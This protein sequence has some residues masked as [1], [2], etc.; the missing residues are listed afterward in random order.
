MSDAKGPWPEWIDKLDPSGNSIFRCKDGRE[1]KHPGHPQNMRHGDPMPDPTFPTWPEDW[2]EAPLLQP[3]R[4]YAPEMQGLPPEAM[5]D[6][7]WWVI[8]ASAL[9]KM[10]ERAQAGEDVGAIMLEEYAN[11][12]SWRPGQYDD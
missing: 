9:R 6:Q 12:R 10:M 7:S 2:P 1:C 3:P 5:R 8:E 11:G 4:P